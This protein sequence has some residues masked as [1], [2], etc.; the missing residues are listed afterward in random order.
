MLYHAGSYQPGYSRNI[1]FTLVEIFLGLVFTVKALKAFLK[2]KWLECW[3]WLLLVI[4]T[5]QSYYAPFLIYVFFLLYL[6]HDGVPHKKWLS[7]AAIAICIAGTAC[8]VV[9]LSAKISAVI[10]G[11]PEKFPTDAVLGNNISYRLV[12][13]ILRYGFILMTSG[14]VYPFGFTLACIALFI[15]ALA[16]KQY[17]M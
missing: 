7:D 15:P 4:A 9:I 3:L 14:G 16:I 1:S 6:S 17:K 10:L 11:I 2:N 12:E 5:Y 13:V 8:L